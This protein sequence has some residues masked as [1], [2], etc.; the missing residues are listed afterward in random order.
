MKIAD[1]I[2]EAKAIDGRAVA[3]VIP[4][5]EDSLRA[6]ELVDVFADLVDA[7]PTEERKC[8]LA[9]LIVKRLGE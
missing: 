6:M 7:E 3:G 1:A 4:P 9:T 2:A 8:T 5:I